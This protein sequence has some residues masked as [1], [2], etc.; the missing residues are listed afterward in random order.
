MIQKDTS[1]EEKT[2]KNDDSF[3]LK[4]WE[5]FNIRLFGSGMD[6]VLTIIDGWIGSKA[7]N[8]WIAT[9]NPEFVMKATKDENFRQLLSKTDLN[10]VDG[11]GLLWAKKIVGKGKFFKGLKTGFEIL[12]GEHRE[13]LVS[14]VDLMNEL[15]K[16]AGK[17]KYKVF[18]LGGF[19]NRAEK[20]MKYFE[21]YNVMMDFCSGEPKFSNK[22]VLEK[23][24]KFKPDILFVAYGM[25]KQEEWIY[26]N[27][28]KADFGVAIG[29]GRSFD[30]YS[31][32]LKRAPKMWRKM[33]LEWF[34]SLIKEP[35]RLKRQ[36]ELPKFAWKV[37]KD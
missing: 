23:I 3:G 25:K 13:G 6:R 22:E 17:K 27:K 28:S 11:V 7:K 16:L 33:G 12:K 32:D 15:V 36:L 10:V 35:K 8:K 5:I 29:V 4:Y 2:D 37:L 9:V 19:D 20:T 18:F 26:E 24:N 21:K 34:Y 31:G 14:G 30:Y 1:L